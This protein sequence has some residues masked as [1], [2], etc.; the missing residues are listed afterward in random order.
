MSKQNEST[1]GETKDTT[2]QGDLVAAI[3]AALT[4]EGVDGAELRWAPSGSYASTLVDRKNIGYVFKQTRGGVR[5][6][7]AATLA[8]LPKSVKLFKPGTRSERFALVGVVKSE[9]DA[10]QA[11]QALAV[12]HAKLNAEQPVET[13][14]TPAAEVVAEAPAKRTRT[15]KPKAA[16]TEQPT[17]EGEVTA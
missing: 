9:K 10:L 4:S 6:E 5:V 16:A 14:A 12:A 11:A 3:M 13:P 7:P 2:E 17:A 8:D 15:R 1:K